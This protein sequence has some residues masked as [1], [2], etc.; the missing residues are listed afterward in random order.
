MLCLQ[1]RPA[2]G[3]NHRGGE[4]Y[5]DRCSPRRHK[6]YMHFMLNQGWLCQF[7]EPDLR[8]PLPRQLTFQ[9][10][11]KIVAMA[12]GGGALKD[13]AARQA[14]DYALQMGRGSM[15]LMLTPEQYAKLTRN[16]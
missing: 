7:L 9:D 10:P 16:R 3:P 8:T 1:S 6:A 2:A 11:A 5:C 15:W 4:R 14:L 12:E 13:L